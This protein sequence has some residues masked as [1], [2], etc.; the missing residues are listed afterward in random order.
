MIPRIG[1]TFAE[2]GIEVGWGLRV[3]C[4]DN[5]DAAVC[6]RGQGTNAAFEDSDQEGR[7]RVDTHD[8]MTRSS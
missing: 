6:R 8:G 3:S 2:R 1:R 5:G 4:C 7:R